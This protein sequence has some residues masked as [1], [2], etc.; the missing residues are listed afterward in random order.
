M[1]LMEVAPASEVL[2]ELRESA[3]QAMNIDPNLLESILANA[4]AKAYSDWDWQGAEEE[5]KRAIAT[6]P[7][8]WMAH[9]QYATFLSNLGRPTEGIRHIEV[10]R[11]LDPLN[12]IPIQTLGWCHYVHGDFRLAED[13]SR[14]A[15]EL[16]PQYSA[17]IIVLG[18][19]LLA[20]DRTEE[21]VRIFEDQIGQG[22]MNPFFLSALIFV[23][24]DAGREEEAIARRSQLHDLGCTSY[25]SPV[26]H[27]LGDV[28][29]GDLKSAIS[30][31]RTAAT[32]RSSLLITLPGV[33]WWDKLRNEHGFTEVMDLVGF[34]NDNPA[35]I[36]RPAN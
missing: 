36:P 16:Q 8:A 30:N 5:F 12:V 22:Q 33:R 24:G 29:L 32:Q 35:V 10:A 19:S 11:R 3:D 4:V 26:F 14:Q 27:A 34:S 23:L 9:H 28:G 7:S 31:L 17:A 13:L 1:S 21:A 2:P 6:N 20:Q 15:L 18:L 25:V